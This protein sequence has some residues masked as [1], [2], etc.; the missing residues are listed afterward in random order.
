MMATLWLD[1][2]YR[3]KVQQ[4]LKEMDMFK[5]IWDIDKE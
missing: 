4:L 2:F 1:A 5:V 3:L